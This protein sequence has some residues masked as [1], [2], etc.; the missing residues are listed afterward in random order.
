[1]LAALTLVGLAG[2][3]KS[4]GK[5]T[6]GFVP[7]MILLCLLGA[8]YILAVHITGIPAALVK[9]FTSAFTGTSAGGG[10]AGS[11]IMVALQCG[12]ARGIFSNESGMGSAAIAA[13][14]AQTIPPVRQSLISM[15]QT[16]T[17]ST[18]SSWSHAPAL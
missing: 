5:V 7:V 14:P 10:F 11:T 12:V 6:A 1:M 18:P 8:L 2:G 4:S 13:T 3:I 15:T 16:F 17:L 9:I